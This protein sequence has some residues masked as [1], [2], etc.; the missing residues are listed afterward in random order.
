VDEV[1]AVASRV[2]LTE[3]SATAAT[4]EGRRSPIFY[5]DEVIG[6]G[7]Q[8]RDN[9]WRPHAEQPAHA[10]AS[11]VYTPKADVLRSARITH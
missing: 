10:S 3:W 7:L 5:D 11:P 8:V 6:F 1:A 9:S 2:T 4:T